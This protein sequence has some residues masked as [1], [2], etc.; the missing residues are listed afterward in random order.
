MVLMLGAVYFS[1]II[2]RFNLLLW[3]TLE[4]ERRNDVVKLAAKKLSQTLNIDLLDAASQVEYK[5]ITLRG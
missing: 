3:R 1:A 2:K 4:M 5:I